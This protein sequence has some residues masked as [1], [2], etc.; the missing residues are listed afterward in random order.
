MHY[1]TVGIIV[2]PFRFEMGLINARRPAVPCEG[3]VAYFVDASAVELD[4]KGS[5][6]AA[7]TKPHGPC[8]RARRKQAGGEGV[9]EVR[10]FQG[11]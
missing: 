11:I 6:A 4:G 5:E 7:S 2:N 8:R 10:K 9:G 1:N 3:Y